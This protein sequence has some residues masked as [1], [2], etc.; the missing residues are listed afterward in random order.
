MKVG[1]LGLGSIGGRHARNLMELGHDVMGYDADMKQRLALNGVLYEREDV[2][3]GADA[4]VIATP[5]AQHYIDLVDCIP[6]GKPIFVEKPMVATREQWNHLNLTTEAKRVI[7]GN[8]LRFRKCVQLAKQWLDAGYIGKPVIAQ[9]FVLQHTDKPAYIR[10]GVTLNW[11]AHEVDLALY[12]LDPLHSGTTVSEADIN[13]D[14]STAILHLCHTDLACASSV[15]LEYHHNRRA[16]CIAGQLGAIFID[17][18]ENVA[19][20]RS[21][22]LNAH[23]SATPSFDQDYVAEIKQFMNGDGPASMATGEDGLRC[24]GLLLDA[25]EKATT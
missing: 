2:I 4:I 15:Y 16:A 10:D 11:G 14:D 8:N 3:G 21:E 12:L 9:F 20:L 13:A 22:E 5:T 25:K 19:T 1:I 23:V 6:T 17:I 18:D 24:L 7:V